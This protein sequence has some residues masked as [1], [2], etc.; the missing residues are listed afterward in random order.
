MNNRFIIILVFSALGITQ[1]LVTPTFSS[2]SMG[3]KI[4]FFSGIVILSAISLILRKRKWI[5]P[6]ALIPLICLDIA[7]LISL[8]LS[9][10]PILGVV[11]LYT[12]SIGL[13][14]CLLV[15]NF[16]HDGLI[17]ESWLYSWLQIIGSIVAILCLYQYVDWIVTGQRNEMLIPYLLPPG[18]RRVTGVFGQSNLTAL[19]L[20]LTIISYFY[21]FVSNRFPGQISRGFCRQIGFFL[22][23]T[24]FFLTGSRAGFL[25]LIAVFVILIWLISMRKFVFPWVLSVKPTL[26]LVAGLIIALLP[27]SPDVAI[28]AYAR[29][30]I[31]I[32]ARFVFWMASFL[33]FLDA[34][35]FGIGLDHFKLFLPSY[36]RKA[37][38]L[39]EFV[40]FEAMGYTHWSHN[41]LFQVLAESG[42]VGFFFLAIFCVM[43]IRMVHEDI[44]QKDPHI[45]RIF[46]FLLILPFF[47]QGMFSWPFRHPALLFLFF[48]ILG[49]I[50]SK[51]SC[52]R[53]YLKPMVGLLMAILLATSLPGIAFF[54]FKE[55]RFNKIKKEAMQKGCG[56]DNFFKA[57]N[58]PLLSFK[59]LHDVLP[60]CI[61]NKASLKNRALMEK[62]KP[63]FMEISD[64]QGTNTQWYNLGIVHRILNEYAQAEYA[65]QKAVERQPEFE[66]GWAA[67]H[68][69]HI[70]EAARQTGRPI[71][72]FLPP[73]IKYSADYNDLLFKRQ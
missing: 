17:S 16:F 24:T 61:S 23:S 19:L 21:S 9:E 72:D 43:L 73:E 65:L 15:C 54:S 56:S 4:A 44:L 13:L 27:L 1:F 29:S 25:S 28:S 2:M 42:L 5:I 58:D 3:G 71:E 18:N 8:V 66:L 41:E 68:V 14:F 35:I 37:H 53:I 57:M 26:I 67:L 12:F 39:L 46:L 38:D 63:Y 6:K 50:V 69:L 30:E 33:M 34:P 60:S 20:L 10:R 48:L 64:L 7:F 62:L 11:E 31:S 49:I 51:A 32:E 59:M 40:Q 70:E 36:A 45:E 47:I 22:V 55:Y 52:F